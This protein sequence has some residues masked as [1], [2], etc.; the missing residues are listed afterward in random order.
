MYLDEKIS[1]SV[2]KDLFQQVNIFSHWFPRLMR[3]LVMLG[4][5]LSLGLQWG[6]QLVCLLP[7]VQV[8]GSVGWHLGKFLFQSPELGIQSVDLLPGVGMGVAPRRSLGGFLPSPWMDIWKGWPWNM[9]EMDCNS[10]RNISVSTAKTEVD[11]GG[12]GVPGWAGFL[13]DC[14]WRDWNWIYGPFWLLWSTDMSVSLWVPLPTGLLTDCVWEG[15][16]LNT[17][18]F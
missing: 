4:W 15:L 8:D 10:P 3:F 7:R 13:H 14:L 11:S 16:E 6:P 2:F 12:T 5:R 17:G 18:P 9:A 1:F